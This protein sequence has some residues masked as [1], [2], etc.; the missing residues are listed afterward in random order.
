MK[1]DDV[2]KIVDHIKNHGG[3]KGDL[4]INVNVNAIPIEWIKKYIGKL[5][6]ECGGMVYLSPSGALIDMLKDWD[7]EN[8]NIKESN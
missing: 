5:D 8:E 6:K 3:I 1:P 7:K 4:F 2:I